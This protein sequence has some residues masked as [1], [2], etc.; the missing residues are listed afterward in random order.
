MGDFLGSFEGRRDGK[1]RVA[2]PSAYRTTLREA[3]TGDVLSVVL[4]PSHRTKCIECWSPDGFARHVREE[5]AL[6]EFKEQADAVRRLMSSE[7]MRVDI[8]GEGRVVLPPR[9]V[10]FADLGEKVTFLTS[11]EHFEIWASDVAEQQLADARAQT[12]QMAATTRLR[13][14]HWNG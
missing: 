1:G 12:A 14:P 9:F 11:G 3:A 7:A 8:D 13:N 10:K 6:Y 4:Y 5:I 2:V